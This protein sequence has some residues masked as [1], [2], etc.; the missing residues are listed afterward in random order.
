[1]Q[2]TDRMEL[3]VEPMTTGQAA[4]SSVAGSP[5]QHVAADSKTDTYQD[6]ELCNTPLHVVRNWPI[7]WC[8]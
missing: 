5:I 6:T 4:S 8:S 3:A 1:M 7:S 2:N